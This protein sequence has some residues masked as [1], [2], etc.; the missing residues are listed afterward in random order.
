MSTLTVATTYTDGSILYESELDVIKDSLE[1]YFNTTKIDDANIQAN[2]LEASVVLASSAVT[3]SKLQSNSI[4]S[5]GLEDST[6]TSTGI[7]AAKLADSSVTTAK[8]ADSAISTNVLASSSVDNSEINSSAVPKTVMLEIPY[9]STALSDLSTTS[10]SL[11]LVGTHTATGLTVGKPNIVLI[12]ST[13]TSSGSGYIRA[14]Q[15]AGGNTERFTYVAVYK[16][17]VEKFRT[18]LGGGTTTYDYKLPPS[19][20]MFIDTDVTTTSHSYALYIAASGGTAS[21]SSL[22]I[23]TLQVI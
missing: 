10:T 22:K 2:T 21:T 9:T 13:T 4:I 17:G 20:I 7:T 16:D 14:L 15:G 1:T 12:Q 18:S 11:T 5:S 3:T 19:S 6:S 8:I 23:E